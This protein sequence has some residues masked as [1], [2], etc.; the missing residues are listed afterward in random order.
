[1]KLCLRWGFTSERY[2]GGFQVYNSN[3]LHMMKL[4]KINNQN[5][6]IRKINNCLFLIKRFFKSV[7]CGRFHAGE[8]SGTPLLLV[9]QQQSESPPPA[10]K[11]KGAEQS[12]F[13]GVCSVK[14]ENSNAALN[15][16][17]Q[18]RKGCA[19]FSAHLI[20]RD[21]RRDT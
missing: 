10:H 12:I 20:P 2:I 5:F 6:I 9:A 19:R 15:I 8:D 18:L 16:C 3:K 21:S 4:T 7:F 1:M 13:L 11:G 14:R 17:Q